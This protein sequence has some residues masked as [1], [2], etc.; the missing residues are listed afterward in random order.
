MKSQSVLRILSVALGSAL[1]LSN[2]LGQTAPP[3]VPEGVQKIIKRSCAALGCHQGQF[4]AMAVG[5]ETADQILAKIGLPSQGRPALKIIDAD[6]PDK[7]Y[8]LLKVNGDRSIKGRRM[9]LR[10]EKLTSEEVQA[11]RDWIG[12]LKKLEA[13]SDTPDRPFPA[14]EGRRFA[15]PAFWGTRLVNLPT[16][17]PIEAGHFLFRI[18][19]RFLESVQSG[20]RT[21]FGLD[22]PSQILLGFGYGI[23]DRLGVMISRANIDQDVELGLSWRAL[24]QSPSGG[25]PFSAAVHL[26]THWTTLERSDRKLFDGANLGFNIGLSTVHQLSDAVSLMVVPA[27]AT[28]STH[29]DPDVRGTFSL[30]LGGRI[31]VLDDIS[32]IGEWIPVL[33]GFKGERSGWGFGIEKKIGGHVFQFF[34]LNSH[35]LTTDQVLPGG[36]LKTGF[37]L[38][39]NIFRTF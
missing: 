22:S 25:L 9:P 10:G 16:T 26:S 31:M 39:F 4:P 14:E 5:L 3:P 19:H 24:T 30:G 27:Y 38:G 11:L 18:S 32:L 2:A 1:A 33:S 17:Q 7:S 21:F 13:D 15:K 37:R 20:T 12:T 6:E 29:G 35:G 8:L 34:A 23:S 36:D 28:N